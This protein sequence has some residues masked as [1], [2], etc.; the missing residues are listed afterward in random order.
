MAVREFVAPS[1]SFKSL[2]SQSAAA[3][4]AAS[5]DVALVIDQQGYVRDLSFQSDEL[6]QELDGTG[7]WVGQ[8]WASTVMVDSRNKVESL[9]REST[10]KSA[11][12]WR[13]L[14]YPSAN[15]ASIPI[16]F[17]AVR[18]EDEGN[19]VAL[20]RDMRQVTQL[21]QR[22]MDAQQAMERD[23]SRLRQAET[24]YR[25]L[26]EISSESVL[27][28]DATSGKIVEVN[29]AAC[30]LLGEVTSFMLGRFFYDFFTNDS[31]VI[32]RSMLAGV[33]AVG[34]VDQIVGRLSNGGADVAVTASIF[35]QDNQSFFLVRLAA[36]SS[37]ETLPTVG[38]SKSQL[39]A[40]IQTAPDG[41]VVTDAEG[42]IMLANPAFLDMAQLAT[43]M[44]AKVEPIQRWLGRPG[45]EMDVLFAN[46]RQHG[47][48]RLFATR[49]RGEFG[50]NA[51]V[52]LSATRFFEAGQTYFGFSIRNVA[53]RLSADDSGGRQLPRSVAQLTEL[54][55][56]V[57]LKDLV[58]ETADVIERLCIEAALEMTEDNRASAA[59]MLG[60]SRQSLYVKL[61]RFGLDRMDA[62]V[63][64]RS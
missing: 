5:T 26:F 7:K 58:R 37:G 2:D 51:D 53:R 32:V 20:G 61:R 49:L 40:M 14:N 57:P 55:G 43:D 4:I 21:Q 12:G 44:Q 52:E 6:A 15:G 64:G 23:Y 25:L 8:S 9:R 46:L 34:T 45:A 62:E 24:R 41:I 63:E 35:R 19:I 27:V 1:E 36:N 33:K 42:H 18:I 56:R 48:V 39:V 29:P 17:S 47:T 13:H 59:S 60:L 3:L 28:I 16:L 54:V 31:A 11:T 38:D 50:A 30:Q 10:L 22:L